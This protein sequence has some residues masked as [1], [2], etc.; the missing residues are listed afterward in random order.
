MRKRAVAVVGATGVAGQ[1]FLAALAGH[2]WFEVTALAASA[3]S[4][5]RP[6]GEAIRDPSGARRWWCSEEPA[7]EFLRLPLEDAAQLDAGRVDLVFAAVESEAARELEPIYARAVPVVSTAAAFRYEPDVPIALPGINLAAHLPLL[8]Q[9]RRRRGWKGFV[10]PLPNCTTVGLAIS[11]KPLLDGFGLERVLMTSMQGLSGAGRSPGVIALDI[12][13][14]LIPYI[15]KEEE[16]V[17]T[18]TA[19][20]LGRLGEGGIEPHPAPVGAT[21]TRAAVLEGHTIAVTVATTRPCSPS[22][23]AEAMRAFRPDYAGLDL[24]SA[25]AHAIIVHDD[26]FRPQPRLD[27]DAEG[28]MAT[29]VGRLRA[30]PAVERGLKYVALSHNTRM[31]AA[32]GA[33]LAA[34]YLCK[35][36]VL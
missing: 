4:A 13:D 18:E 7:A 21:C 8:E 16:K 12:L 32:K 15:P 19:K 24:P 36:G 3:R 29:S 31:G 23:A 34:E 27:R 25:P 1:Q 28:G 20:I 11:L 22:A 17:A 10:L 6:Y 5:G 14:N 35:T 33:V 26:P 2:P 9:Q 30:E